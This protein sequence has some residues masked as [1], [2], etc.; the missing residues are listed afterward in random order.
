MLGRE[1]NQGKPFQTGEADQAGQLSGQN[2]VGLSSNG[3]REQNSG[4]GAGHH[5]QCRATFAHCH[6]QPNQK[7]LRRKTNEQLLLLSYI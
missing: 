6:Q 2:E 7:S 3:G 5:K 4:Q 1:R